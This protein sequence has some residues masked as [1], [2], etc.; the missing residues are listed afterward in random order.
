[1]QPSGSGCNK[2][3]CNRLDSLPIGCDGVE[4]WEP[5]CAF[6]INKCKAAEVDSVTVG[7]SRMLVPR[8]TNQAA[9][10]V[11]ASLTKSE[12]TPSVLSCLGNVIASR[13][14]TAR[15]DRSGSNRVWSTGVVTPSAISGRH[16]PTQVSP[17]QPR[18]GL[19]KNRG[20]ASATFSATMR[21][22]GAASG[23][24]RRGRGDFR[25]AHPSA[26]WK[27]CERLLESPRH[28]RSNPPHGTRHAVLRFAWSNC[29]KFKYN[30]E[31][32]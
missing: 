8:S 3:K 20:C 1:V 31:F 6:T 25:V 18:C 2:R 4:G 16:C 17:P 11:I 27:L 30:H 5:A 23:P 12:D 15:S 21:H 22:P 29:R 24:R 7:R 28:P 13:P 19:G 32:E 14:P 10:G 26:A 9:S